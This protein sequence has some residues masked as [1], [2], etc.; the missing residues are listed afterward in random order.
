MYGKTPGNNK[1][2]S[3]NCKGYKLHVGKFQVLF[4]RY[5]L[6]VQN[7]ERYLELKT[8]NLQQNL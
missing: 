6:Q 2:E 7:F 4:I 1:N 5:V 8:S 3:L